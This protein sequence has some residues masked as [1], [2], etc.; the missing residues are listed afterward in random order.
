MNVKVNVSCLKMT[1]ICWYVHQL[2]FEI[3]L[4][5]AFTGAAALG[6]AALALALVS[7]AP[8]DRP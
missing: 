4:A 5:G 2:P 7:A 1:L 8:P 3:Q 6:A